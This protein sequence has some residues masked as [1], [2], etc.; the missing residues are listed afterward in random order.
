MGSSLFF[1]PVLRQAVDDILR[2]DG[3]ND[4]A[5]FDH[6]DTAGLPRQRVEDVDQRRLARAVPLTLAPAAA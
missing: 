2:R 6:A 5:V 3:A 4:R 1:A